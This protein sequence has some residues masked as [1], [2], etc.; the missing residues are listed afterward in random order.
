MTLNLYSQQDR[1]TQLFQEIL[2]KKFGMNIKIKK[3]KQEFH[4]KPV[5]FLE[6]RT[7]TLV[8]V[9]TQEIIAH[10]ESSINSLTKSLKSIMVM[11]LKL[12][13]LLK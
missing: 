11:D 9:C 6:L 1:Q 2:H 12:H 8:L 13:I 10:I 5:F 7:L 4:L 3:M